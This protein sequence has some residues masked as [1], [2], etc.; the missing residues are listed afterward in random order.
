MK[1][2]LLHQLG[3]KS[4]IKTRQYKLLS[5]V[6]FGSSSRPERNSNQSIL[7]VLN[8][9]IYSVRTGRQVDRG[10]VNAQLNTGV[11]YAITK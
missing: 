8:K 1:A 3:M 5:R 7:F 6:T 9:E 10:V 4:M 11:R 2:H